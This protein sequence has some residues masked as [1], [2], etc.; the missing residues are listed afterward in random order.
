MPDTVRVPEQAL[1]AVKTLTPYGGAENFCFRLRRYLLDRGCEAT[2][3][4]GEN[5]TDEDIGVVET[6][7]VRPGRFLKTLS[8]YRRSGEWAAK[9]GQG[10]PSMSFGNTPGCSIFRSGGTH[11]DFLIQ[12]LRA[13][14]SAAGRLA[15]AVR[16]ALTPANYL[17]LL[18]EPRLY[19]HPETKIILAISQTTAQAVRCRY[20]QLQAHIVTLPNGVDRS[21]FNPE[22]AQT[23]RPGGRELL[24]AR[25]GDIVAGFCSTNFALKGLPRL[26]QALAL[27]PE[28]FR[29][30][31]A[32]GRR[33]GS[34]LQLAQSL[35]VQDR[36]RFLGKVADMPRF[37]AGL[38]VFCHPSYYDTFGSVVAE[39]LAMGVPVVTTSLVG[40]CGL[41]EEGV[42]GHVLP[43]AAPQPLA[44]AVESAA[45]LKQPVA[46]KVEDDAAV[47]A[48]YSNLLASVQE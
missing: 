38:D 37:Y 22:A 5:A 48:A 20:P 14:P 21:R 36:V 12:S 28:N 24:Q 19:N 2:T 30:V 34:C 39:A 45:D 17:R 13:Q 42:N 43:D 1:L 18:L 27:L 35:G 23:L 47:F 41:V 26:I 32:G 4:C 6:G 46:S 25:T 33:P 3:L 16:R 40:A 29:L 31:V 10:V 44:R 8:F 15:K 7:V 11:L 9:H